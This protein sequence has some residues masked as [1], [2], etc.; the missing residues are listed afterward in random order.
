MQGSV[1]PAG[2][3]E[4]LT[5]RFV[6]ISSLLLLTSCAGVVDRALTGQTAV[7]K[8]RTDL[9]ADID[10]R[11]ALQKDIARK[12]AEVLFLSS[13]G[14]SCGPSDANYQQLLNLDFK[15]K[16][17]KEND[18]RKKARIDYLKRTFSDVATVL[19][20]GDALDK[21]IN[22]QADT[23]KTL[24]DFQKL[25]TTVSGLVPKEFEFAAK[26]LSA[27]VSLGGVAASYDARLKLVNLAKRNIDALDRARANIKL[28]GVNKQ[29]TELERQMFLDWDKCAYDR[30]RFLR[31]YDP[32]QPPNYLNGDI[33]LI[34]IRT[35]GETRSPVLDF[36]ILYNKYI[37][38]KEAFVGQLND[39]LTDIDAIISA[40]KKLSVLAPETAKFD[41]FA[42]AINEIAGDANT[43]KT[44]VQVLQTNLQ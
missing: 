15:A 7:N 35:M 18:E 17:K 37:D 14:Y 32:K 22:Y 27:V 26:D 36:S 6:V 39:Y 28:K 20:Y 23:A 13:N 29:M 21:A 12:N 30:L 5:M 3:A 2:V 44:N 25:M 4:E 31:A 42:L 1:I 9:G 16:S 40:N 38:E 10:L 19:T 8:L 34:K 43:I 24:A 41:D 11:A 33:E